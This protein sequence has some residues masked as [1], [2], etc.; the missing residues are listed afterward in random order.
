MPTRVSRLSVRVVRFPTSRS[1]DGSDA[2]NVAPDYSCAYVVL[3]TD[4]EH[5]EGHGLTFTTGRGTEVVVAAV[6]ALEH[7][8]VGRTLES[9]TSDMAGFWRRMTGDPHLRWL[10][11]D[12]GV[13]HLATAAVVN[14]VWELWAKAEGKPL[15][16][17]LADMTPEQLVGCVDFRYLS[18]ALMAEEAIALLR[19][20]EE[21]K[22]L[23]EREMLEAGFPAYT[24][25]AGWLGY[26][27]DKIAR[28]CR[29]AVA[30]GFV[31]FKIKVG[32]SVEDDVRRCE[33]LRR[34]IGPD[35]LLMTDANQVWEVGQAIEHMKALA[36]L[37][38][39]WIEEPTS[40]DDVLGHAAIAKA[41]HPLGI[42]VATGEHCQN[43]ILFKQFLAAG[44]MQF[45]QPDAARLGGVNE[46]L[47]VM[48]LARKFN[49]PV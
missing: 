19:A 22:A 35:R 28:L 7:L 26:D 45:C 6:R 3:H 41:L 15:W 40:P 11:P 36:H 47:A 12:K 48:L 33:I 24:T 4:S 10:G 44:A 13:A 17:L 37:H 8:V 27:D 29:D 5:L 23:R 49:V 30:E 21:G 14:A 1:L 34:E 31:A 43:R 9:L 42:G 46:V 18:D 25:S 16:K 38:P 39:W 20:V 2:M 32:A